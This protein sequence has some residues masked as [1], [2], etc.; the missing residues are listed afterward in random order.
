MTFRPSY[1]IATI[2]LFAAEVLIALFLND[3]FIR[4]YFG[5]FLV[6]IL[7]YCFVRSF[8]DTPVITTAIGVLVFAFAIEFLQ[9]L[10]LLKLFHRENSKLAKIVLGS[11]FEWID[12]LAYTLG[13]AAIIIFEKGKNIGNK[14]P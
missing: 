8:F 14:K 12:L 5:D 3:R 4:P 10:N 2:I 7:V 1:F 13:I 6:V 9:Y 11:S